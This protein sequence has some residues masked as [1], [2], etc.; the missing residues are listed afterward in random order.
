MMMRRG[1]TAAGLVLTAVVLVAGG[2]AQPARTSPTQHLCGA[3][4]KQFIRA[5]A[6]SNTQLAMLGHDYMAGDL[7]P[8]SAI[9][10]ADDAA[11]AI[12]VTAPHDP[13]LKLTRVLMRG[14][15]VEYGRAIHAQ[16]KGGN[17]GKHMYRSY[18]LANYAHQVLTDAQPKLEPQGCSVGELLAQ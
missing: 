7:G 18:S 12:E 8:K 4:D 11:L 13:S 1:L 15:L 17:P 16:W 3:V 2:R 6:L 14:M 9:A 10:Q 5:A